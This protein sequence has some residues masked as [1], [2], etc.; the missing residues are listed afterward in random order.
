MQKI[1]IGTQD[2]RIAAIALANNA[3]VVTRNHKDFSKIPDLSLE[4][5]TIT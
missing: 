5:W 2:L 3:I 4:D 1:N